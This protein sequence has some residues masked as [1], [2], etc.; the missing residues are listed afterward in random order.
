MNWQLFNPSSIKIFEH[1]LIERVLRPSAQQKCIHQNDRHHNTI[2]QND[3]SHIG[4]HQN[5]INHN[6]I[7][8]N[9]K[10]QNDIQRNNI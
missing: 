3:I 2:Q 1:S 4:I 7:H 8:Q 10:Y 6:G 9:D 5:D